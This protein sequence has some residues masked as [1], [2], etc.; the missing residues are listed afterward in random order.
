MWML[1]MNVHGPLHI[2]NNS[3]NKSQVRYVGY[4][5][6]NGQQPCKKNEQ[7]KLEAQRWSPLFPHYRSVAS[8]G[9][10]LITFQPNT[11]CRGWPQGIVGH[12]H[13]PEKLCHLWLLHIQLQG[14]LY[15]AMRHWQI[16]CIEMTWRGPSRGYLTVMSLLYYFLFK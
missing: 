10:L 6:Q 5:I 2:H 8:K 4:Y 13:A 16:F 3:E 9:I 7:C 14:R 12:F 15:L 1:C 11:L